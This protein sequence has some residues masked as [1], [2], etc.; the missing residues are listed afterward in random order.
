L[1]EDSVEILLAAFKISGVVASQ[2]I[3]RMGRRP[4]GMANMPNRKEL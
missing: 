2:T 1:R 4:A 3:S